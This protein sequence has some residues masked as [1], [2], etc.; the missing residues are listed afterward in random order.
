M[1]A[2]L[3][4]RLLGEK[5]NPTRVALALVVTIGVWLTAHEVNDRP[6]RFLHT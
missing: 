4:N 5:L 6:H 2:I 1:V 3:A